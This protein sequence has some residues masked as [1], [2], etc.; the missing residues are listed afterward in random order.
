MSE[1]VFV[2]MS[3]GVDSSVSAYLLKQAGFAV[4]GIHLLLTG[5][6]GIND[7]KEKAH[8]EHTCRRLDIPLVYLNLENEFRS[9]VMEYYYHEYGQGHTPN[10]CVRCNTKIKFGLLMD[11]V[12]EM[13][14]RYLATGHYAGI[15]AE[16][17]E[18]RLLKGRDPCKDQSYFLYLLGQRELKHIL[19]PVGELPKTG[20]KKIA[21]GLD[22]MAYAR[23]ESRDICFIPEGSYQ[24]FMSAHIPSSPGDI[25]DSSGQVLGRHR[26]LP[27][28]TIG[29][30]QGMGVSAREPLYVIKMEP[31]ANRL[32][33]GPASLLFK[34]TLTAFN[35]HWVSGRLPQENIKVKARVRYRSPESEASLQIENGIAR[36]SFTQPQRAIAPGQS[37]VFYQENRVLG[38]G[39]IAETD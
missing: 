17:D 26:G 20:V 7:E 36:V 27:F 24:A 10:P 12:L 15:S 37:V 5:D 31:A 23:H 33:I 34:H 18:Y 22:I 6:S 1:R 29:Q 25:V 30:R 4:T 39:I 8:L 11:K 16:G 19:F 28:Y 9:Q 21:S 32:V 35:L 2:A 3:G 13:G 14:G 38:G